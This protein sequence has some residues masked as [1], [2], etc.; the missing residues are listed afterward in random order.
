M[1]KNSKRLIIAIPVIIA[2][3]LAALI[4]SVLLR[5]S[6]NHQCHSFTV[7]F[8]DLSYDVPITTSTDRYTGQNITNQGYH[9]ENRT[10]QITIENQPFSSYMENGAE[11]YFLP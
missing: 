2:L 7:S 3:S 5:Q 6:L 4:S 10:I 9:V 11:D 8:V 1:G